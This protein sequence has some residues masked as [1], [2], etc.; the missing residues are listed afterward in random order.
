MIYLSHTRPDIAY[1]VSLV[2][3]FM[4]NQS[5]DHMNVV[6]RILRYLKSSLGR[7][8]I[9]KK[10]DH[11]NVEGYSDVDWAGSSDRKSTFVYFNFIGR[12]L[13]TWRNKKQ[14]IIT[15]SSAKAEFRGISKGVCELLWLKSLLSEIGYT[16]SNEMNL[17]CDNQTAIQ[18]S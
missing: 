7:G 17:Y 12:N 14:K 2:S 1:V 3:Q 11:L 6:I 5:K 8:L 9:F 16:P 4:Y 15:V 18:I 13:V 10:H